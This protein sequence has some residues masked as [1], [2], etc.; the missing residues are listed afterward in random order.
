M[1][2]DY[3]PLGSEQTYYV[4]AMLCQDEDGPLYIKFGRSVDI[5]RRLNSL[6]TGTP[7]PPRYFCYV[8]VSGPRTQSQ[9]EI[10]LHRR[11]KDRR[12]SG[13]WFKFD[14]ASEADRA[15]FNA[16]CKAEFILVT[17]RKMAWEKVSVAAVKSYV[18]LGKQ[19]RFPARRGRR[20]ARN[21]S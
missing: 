18:E 8:K 21:R 10:A 7:I 14:A 5:D 6:R 13:E 9:L 12:T 1:G 17:G 4:Y 20:I 15:E 11:F 3:V 19:E 2:V 16:G